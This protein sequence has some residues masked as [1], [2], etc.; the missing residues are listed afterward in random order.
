[1]RPR[2]REVKQ[3]LA[4]LLASREHGFGTPATLEQAFSLNEDLLRAGDAT[5]ELRLH[6]AE[7]AVTLNRTAD[8]DAHLKVLRSTMPDVSRVWYLSGLAA[9]QQLDTETAR[10]H[11]R[12]ASSPQTPDRRFQ[13]WLGALHQ[14]LRASGISGGRWQGAS[15]TVD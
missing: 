2:D 7:I 1:M 14:P 13:A 4:E 5:N 10:D 8:A 3:R 12:H 11:F 6:Q 9:L 15:Q